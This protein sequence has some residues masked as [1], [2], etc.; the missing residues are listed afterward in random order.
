MTKQDPK[1][2]GSC[3]QIVSS[4][5]FRSDYILLMTSLE[6]LSLKPA[7]ES[8]EILGKLAGR[9]G[10]IPRSVCTH[11]ILPSV[12][13][14][15]SMATIDFQNRDAREQCRQIIQSSLSLLA[16]LGDQQKLDESHFTSK[17]LPSILQ[18]W[19]MSD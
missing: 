10:G 3:N 19:A 4:A 8:I 5:A 13:R 16:L 14:A 12:G 9:S 2:R 18:L 11:K 17:V 15:L 1:R 6:E 7:H